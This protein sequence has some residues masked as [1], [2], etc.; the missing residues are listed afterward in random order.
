MGDIMQL[1]GDFKLSV[2]TVRKFCHIL[3]KTDKINIGIEF[4]LYSELYSAVD[5]SSLLNA[6]INKYVDIKLYKRQYLS[7]HKP[8]I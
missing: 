1:Y 6:L 7:P 4:K 3:S 5:R 8:Y 2:S